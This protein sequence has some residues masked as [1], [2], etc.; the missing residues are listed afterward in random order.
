MTWVGSN[1]HTVTAQCPFSRAVTAQRPNSFESPRACLILVRDD[2]FGGPQQRQKIVVFMSWAHSRV[3]LP[4]RLLTEIPS[5]RQ[6]PK[7][8]DLPAAPAM[9]SI[10]PKS[11]FRSKQRTAAPE[12]ALIS[13]HRRASAVLP[14]RIRSSSPATTQDAFHRRR[15]TGDEL[16]GPS[17][18]RSAPDDLF[19]VQYHALGECLRHPHERCSCVRAQVQ[20]NSQSSAWRELGNRFK[21]LQAIQ[22]SVS[23]PSYERRLSSRRVSLHVERSENPAPATA[24]RRSSQAGDDFPSSQAGDDF[25]SSPAGVMSKSSTPLAGQRASGLRNDCLRVRLHTM[26][27]NSP[28]PSRSGSPAPPRSGTPNG[29][30]TGT[31]KSILRRT[32]AYAE[33]HK[34]LRA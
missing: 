34:S 18:T 7:A 26:A 31:P 14:P 11:L 30:P 32:S 3:F 16:F 10:L 29:T 2:D 20:A 19:P 12:P 17:R 6:H 23:D 22:R 33:Q 9:P 24:S 1:E 25:P 27:Q 5:R 15:S 8:P 13:V 28:T 21:H 4:S